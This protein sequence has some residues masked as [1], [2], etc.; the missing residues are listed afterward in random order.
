MHYAHL[1][2][3][4]SVG[5]FL[6]RVHSSIDEL[7]VKT[8]AI[9]LPENTQDECVYTGGQNESFFKTDLHIPKNVW[10]NFVGIWAVG[11]N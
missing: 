6:F 11:T 2:K 7:S 3:W 5:A 1:F 8:L 4:R 10:E 9:L